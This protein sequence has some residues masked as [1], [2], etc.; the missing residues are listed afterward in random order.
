[1]HPGIVMFSIS[2]IQNFPSPTSCLPSKRTNPLAGYFALSDEYFR[3][4]GSI[5]H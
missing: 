5:L 2:S 4:G 1:M 3:L